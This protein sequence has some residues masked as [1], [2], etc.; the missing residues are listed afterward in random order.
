MPPQVGLGHL[1]QCNYCKKQGV[2]TQG[3]DIHDVVSCDLCKRN[4]DGAGA[5][6]KETGEPRTVTVSANAV[7][8]LVNPL[9]G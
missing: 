7:A 3:E 4:P 6:L 9:G 8:H 5:T 1:V 2:V